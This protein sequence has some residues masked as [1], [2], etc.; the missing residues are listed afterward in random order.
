MSA[1]ICVE[2]VLRCLCMCVCEM[3]SNV[4]LKYYS[5]YCNRVSQANLELISSAGLAAELTL[6]AL[7]PLL[8]FW[9]HSWVIM[10]AW[11]LVM[12]WGFDL[13]SSHLCKASQREEMLLNQAI[14]SALKCSTFAAADAGLLTFAVLYWD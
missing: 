5:V 7:S 4:I 3:I 8:T 1:Y 13:R 2:Y 12:T 6:E 14:T 9:N 10:P 11:L